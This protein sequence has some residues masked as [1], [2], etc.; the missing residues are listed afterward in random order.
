MRG[1]DYDRFIAK[2]TKL[3]GNGCWLWLA[4][5]GASGYGHFSLPSAKGYRMRSAHR[6]SWEIHNGK[7]PEGMHVCHHC[8][9]KVCVNPSHLFIGTHSDNMR[10]KESKGRGVYPDRVGQSNGNSKLTALQV[11][12]IRDFRGPARGRNIYLSK[13]FGVHVSTVSRI[14]NG[15]GWK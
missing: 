10:D 6:V 13:K 4:G 15:K 2:V 9:V 11:V 12:E 7:I 5:V 8:D 14:I 1:S 3:R